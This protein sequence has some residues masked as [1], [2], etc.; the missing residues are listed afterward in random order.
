MGRT[1]RAGATGQALSLVTQYD[2]EVYS[3]VEAAIGKKLPEFPAPREEVMV[4]R[5][6]T[7]EAQRY[8]RTE[9]KNLMDDRG[10]KGSVLSGRKAGQ[11]AMKRRRD[12]MDADEG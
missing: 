5:E 3:R 10:N 11:S 8:S 4:Y 7:E 2:L 1:A 12:N 9:M 6:R